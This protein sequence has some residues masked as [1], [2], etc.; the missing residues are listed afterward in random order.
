[1]QVPLKTFVNAISFSAQA[2]FP[3]TSEFIEP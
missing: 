1:M 3:Q 2:D